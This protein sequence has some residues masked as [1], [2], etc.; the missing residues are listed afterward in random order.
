MEIS[1]LSYKE[2]MA[3]LESILAKMQEPEPDIDSLA[4]NTR[5]ATLLIEHCRNK[6]LKTEEDLAKVLEQ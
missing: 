4:E 1:E 5:T 3:R 6:L 2:A